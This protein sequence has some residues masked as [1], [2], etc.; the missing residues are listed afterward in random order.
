MSTKDEP[1]RMTLRLPKEIRKALE[2][3]AKKSHTNS[4]TAEIIER[5]QKSLILEPAD[6]PN[7]FSM[8]RQQAVQ[9]QNTVDK[10]ESAVSKGKITRSQAL[11]ILTEEERVLLDAFHALSKE[12]QKAILAMISESK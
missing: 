1:I 3:A 2:A 10:I 12:K 5:L 11:Q 8:I 9:I 6:I 4:V 7:E